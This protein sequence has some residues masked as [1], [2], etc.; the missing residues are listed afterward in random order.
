MS[1]LKKK[2]K[3]FTHT[4]LD[5][6]GCFL[7]LL[8]Q[9]IMWYRDIKEGN[10]EFINYNELEERLSKYI[11]EQ[12]YINYEQTYI[13]DLSVSEELGN[14]I[15]T[16][17]KEGKH[18]FIWV[19]HH[20][21]SLYAKE[22]NWTNITTNRYN[23]TLEQYGRP[24]CATM[25]LFEM[26]IDNITPHLLFDCID[27]W[28]TWAWKESIIGDK[29]KSINDLLYLLGIKDFIK[30][31]EEYDYDIQEVLNSPEVKLLLNI[32]AKNKQEY[33]ETKIKNGYKTNIFN[34]KVFVIFAD[35]YISELGSYI[36]ESNK[37]ID[38]CILIN[39]DKKSISYRTAKKDV[40]C[41][42][43][44]KKVGGGGN[45]ATSG[46]PF[47]DKIQQKIFKD[48]IEILYKQ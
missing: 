27:D 45:K 7:V 19:D 41:C 2:T 9:K 34:H 1:Q 5:G 35:K 15:N 48:T 21:T 14:K 44:A 6:V 43:F 24:I 22:Y 28:D 17:V 46:S 3:L 29:A 18:N 47:S 13:T 39:L 10:V 23:K 38:M 40:D 37:D 8:E 42:E 31:Y 12:E 33:F 26:F 4:D 16:L 11:N 20:K 32:D 25:L 30:K 36:C